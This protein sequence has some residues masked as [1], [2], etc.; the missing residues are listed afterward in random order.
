MGKGKVPNLLFTMNLVI[1]SVL[2]RNYILS[3]QLRTEEVN[4]SSIVT[5]GCIGDSAAL[6]PLIFNE[7][8]LDNI[9]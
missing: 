8:F 1:L 6:I 9:S 2:I 5:D 3:Y 4:N 7:D